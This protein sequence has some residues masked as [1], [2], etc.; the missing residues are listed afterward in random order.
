MRRHPY[1]DTQFTRGVT[2]A[3]HHVRQGELSLHHGQDQTLLR[4]A[5]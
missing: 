2:E 4:R 5:R 1:T 3:L